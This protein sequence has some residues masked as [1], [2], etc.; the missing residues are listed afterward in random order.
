MLYPQRTAR[1][2]RNNPLFGLGPGLGAGGGGLPFISSLVR[3]Y[4]ST[5]LLWQ[6]SGETTPAVANADPIGGIQDQNGVSD[7]VQATASNKAALKT[8][9]FGGA[10]SIDFDGVQDRF[11]TCATALSGLTAMTLFLAASTTN[12]GVGDSGEVLVVDAATGFMIGFQGNNAKCGRSGVAWDLT[13]TSTP[14]SNNTAF[15]IVARWDGSTMRLR[16]NGTNF[17]T[18]SANVPVMAGAMRLGSKTATFAQFDAAAALV[19][20]ASLTDAQC[21]LLETYTRS[22]YGTP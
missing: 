22:K 12:A 11:L 14:L 9:V 16:C 1:N 4:E 17:V 2:A 8:A 5:G 7:L 20:S 19:Y 21:V 10:R 3:R 13:T 18:T 15:T 6:D